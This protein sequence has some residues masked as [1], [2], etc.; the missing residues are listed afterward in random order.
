MAC[1]SRVARAMRV[2][3]EQ[4]HDMRMV[5]ASQSI[6]LSQRIIWKRAHVA[7]AYFFERDFCTSGTFE[8]TVDGAEGTFTDLFE[9]FVVSVRCLRHVI[10]RRDARRDAAA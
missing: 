4:W 8:C 3:A 1:S 5:E 2:H 10:A 7:H 9:D 6:Q